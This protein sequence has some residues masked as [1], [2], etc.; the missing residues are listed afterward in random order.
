[1]KMDTNTPKY[2]FKK[3]DDTISKIDKAMNTYGDVIKPGDYK[4]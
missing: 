3:W 1:M 4:S 2:I